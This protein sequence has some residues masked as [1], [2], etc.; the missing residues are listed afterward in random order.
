MGRWPPLA[1]RP[2]REAEPGL[3]KAREA[4]DETLTTIRKQAEAA[5]LSHQLADEKA[6]QGALV[7]AQA[8]RQRAVLDLERATKE[9]PVAARLDETNNALTDL[10]GSLEEV[11]RQLSDAKFV[12]YVVAQRQRALLVEASVLLGSMTAG[13]YGFSPNFEVVDRLSGQTR[14]P[15]TLSGGETFVASLSL[16]LALVELAGRRGGR[17]EALFLDE[18]FGSLDASNLGEALAVLGQQA[19]GGRLVA[20]ISHLRAVAESIDDVLFV[21]RGPKGSEATWLRGK[22]RDALVEKDVEESLL[23]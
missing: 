2:P 11:R 6:L 5:L 4:A 7:A 17:V 16:A 12:K 23:G 10:L 15:R 19:S 21:K 18:G 1:A 22:D 20:V 14:S 9:A 3:T 8:D 13:R